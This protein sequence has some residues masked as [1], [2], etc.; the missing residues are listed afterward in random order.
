VRGHPFGDCLYP[1]WLLPQP[2][3][4][5]V[6]RNRPHYHGPLRLLTRAHRIEA[7]WWDRQGPGMA[8]RDYFIAR[9]EE[10]GL[11]WIYCER[12]ASLAGQAQPHAQ[13]PAQAR[14]YLQGLYA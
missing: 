4:L 7:A 11:L 14:W 5:E 8:L 10:V 1:P 6:L 12:P 3:R 13:V 2:L 9:S